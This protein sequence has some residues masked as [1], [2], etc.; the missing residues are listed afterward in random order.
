M[1]IHRSLGVETLVALMAAHREYGTMGDEPA[2][3]F[4]QADVDRSMDRLAAEPLTQLA[5][6]GRD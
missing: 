3:R 4:C 5:R 6:A 1:R 2:G